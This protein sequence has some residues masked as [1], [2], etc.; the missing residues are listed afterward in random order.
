MN[1]HDTQWADRAGHALALLDEMMGF[2]YPAALGA[3]A[4]LGVADHLAGGPRTAEELAEATGTHAPSLLRVLRLLAG[5]DVVREDGTGRFELTARGELLRAGVP[6]S[7]RPALANFTGDMTWRPAG[8]LVTS[9][10][11]G[12]PAFEAV[13]GEPYFAHLEKDPAAAGD[14]HRAMASITEVFEYLI[15]NALE[16]PDHGTVVDVGGGLGGMLL[17]ILRAW[18]GLHGV[19]FD[20]PQALDR[21]RL[22]DLGDESRWE[23]A[24]GDFFESVPSGADVYIIKSVLHDWSDERCVTILRNCRQAM[25]ADGRVLLVESLVEPGDRAMFAKTLDV[26]MMGL[27]LGRERTEADF[28]Q[29]LNEAGLKLSRVMPTPAPYAVIE[30]V[31]A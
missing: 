10:Q 22:G 27:V 4:K 29:L 1:T 31:A 16:L 8:Q 28:A 5:H 2:A 18:T 11:R 13:F 12:T 26:I 30:A 25:A 20:R 9:L 23:L 6:M 17:E 15:A 14:F 19:L 3:A 7:V 21:H 24:A